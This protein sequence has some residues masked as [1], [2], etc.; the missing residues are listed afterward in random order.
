MGMGTAAADPAEDLEKQHETALAVLKNPPVSGILITEVA[1]ES[2]AA[3]RGM[4]AGDILT[5]YYGKRV[6]TLEALSQEVAE[7]VARRLEDVA[8]GQEVM[9]RVRRGM[10][11]EREIPIPLP[12]EVLGIRGVEV[13]A[14]V[15]GPRNPPP[16]PRG[17][18]ALD[19][20]TVTQTLNADA[21]KTRGAPVAFRMFE[22]TEANGAATQ[23]AAGKAQEDWTGW[24]TCTMHAVGQDQLSGNIELHHLMGVTET[25][26]Q[27]GTAP[28]KP[29]IVTERSTF[30]FRLRLGD[31]KTTPAFVLEDFGARFA[32][33]RGPENAQ[34]SIESRRAGETLAT[35]NA[36][37]MGDGPADFSKADKH[38][39][40]APLNVLP[41]AAVPWVAAA[42]PQG[43]GDAL[44]VYLLSARECLPRPG[45]ILATQ[46]KQPLPSDPAAETTNQAGWRVNL[47]HCGVVVE[48]YWFDDMRRLLCVQTQGPQSVV[49]RRVASVNMATTPP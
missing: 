11:G 42:L 7:A 31:Y 29:K 17:T 33:P 49:A 9:A 35:T 37:A 6:T 38:A 22:R 16:N 19:W 25:T 34:I 26:T 47:M 40:G 8:M 43:K 41:Q 14:G 3:A 21:E 10:G 30:H 18:L 39:N 13:K 28:A 46:G 32:D 1:P 20:K 23:A 45:Y 36:P 24:E 4:R 2:P 12:R 15:P 44:A 27:P 48:S 5:E